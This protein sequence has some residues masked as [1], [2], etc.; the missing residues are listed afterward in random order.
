M[1]PSEATLDRSELEGASSGGPAGAA[2]ELALETHAVPQFTGR[3]GELAAELGRLRAEGFRVR[4]V[5]AD[6]RQAVH[7]RQILHE[8]DLEAQAA[9]GLAGDERLAVVVGEC[10]A[11]FAI[12]ALGLIVLTEGEV[13]GARRRALRR[14]KY[15]RGAALTAFTDLEIGDVVV[16]EDHG[17][18][19]YLGLRTMTIGDREGDFLLLEYAEANQLYVPVER[20]DLVSKYLGA[21]AAAARLDRLGGASWQRVKDSVRAALREM[22]E[23]LLRLYARRAVALG[24]AFSP[25]APWQREFDTA[26]RFE[27]TPDQLRGLGATLGWDLARAEA[28]GRL[29]L[30]Y[31]SPVELSTDRYLD[32]ARQQIADLGARRVVLDGLSS[33][34]LSVPSERRFKELVY[35]STKHFRDSGATVYMTLELEEALGSGHLTGRAISSLADNVIL[36]R[37]LEVRDR[38]ERAVLVLKARGTAHDSG[39]RHFSIDAS[40]PH[41]GG[42]FADVRSGSGEISYKVP[43]GWKLHCRREA[44]GWQ[45]Y[46]AKYEF[47]LGGLRF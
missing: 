16:H 26:F 6:P 2:V 10:S 17:L 42:S 5:A 33:L 3:F 23:E 21:D 44:V 39:V 25:D 28:S 4:L 18:G 14:P 30:S 9:P 7:L 1:T 8:H 27:E 35:A 36:L 24:H 37:H 15:Q 20:L 34:A 38:L 11:G 19:R 45:V 43:T 31:T 29:R 12:P 32:Q 40:G 46:R 47:G 22:A 13:F 41:V